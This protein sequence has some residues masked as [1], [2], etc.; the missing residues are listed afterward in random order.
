MVS[1]TTEDLAAGEIA[2]S[3]GALSLYLLALSVTP[4]P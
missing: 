1:L 3:H 4:H 2:V